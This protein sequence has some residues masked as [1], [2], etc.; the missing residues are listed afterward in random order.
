M[1]HTDEIKQNI[2]LINRHS[3]DFTLKKLNNYD[4]HVR[5]APKAV[6]EKFHLDRS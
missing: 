5:H 2:E 1:K 3:P 4:N 6:F